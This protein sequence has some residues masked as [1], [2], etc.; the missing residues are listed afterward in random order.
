MVTVSDAND[1]I[2]DIGYFSHNR[3]YL[4]SVSNHLIPISPFINL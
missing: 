1:D 2:Y 3:H 4:L